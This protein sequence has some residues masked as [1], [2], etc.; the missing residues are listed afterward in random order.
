[1]VLY[2]DHCGTCTTNAARGRRYQRAGALEWL[3][4]S[5][6]R[7]QAILR[8]RGLLG[9]EQDSLIV[10]EGGR[11]SMGSASVVRA[12]LGLRW[13]W[14]ASAALWIVP[15]PLRDAVYRRVSANRARHA[16]CRLP[17]ERQRS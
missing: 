5:T 7:A 15:K 8:E 14:K 17:A 9:K 12:V 6:P 1:I 13:P 10:I 3:G 2:D 11:V 16:E 4:N